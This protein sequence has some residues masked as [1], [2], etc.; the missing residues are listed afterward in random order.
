MVKSCPNVNENCCDFLPI[1]T[2]EKWHISIT[3]DPIK[4]IFFLKVAYALVLDA[5]L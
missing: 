1:L 5:Q 3:T 4:P 2:H